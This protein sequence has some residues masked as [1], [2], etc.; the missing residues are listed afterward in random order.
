VVAGS[1]RS[2]GTVV[3]EPTGAAG[4]VVAGSA[5]TAWTVA[6]GAG[7]AWAGSAWT[8]ATWTGATRTTGAAW[9]AGSV[10]STRLLGCGSPVANRGRRAVG[11]AGTRRGAGSTGT[12]T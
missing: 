6:A 10:A 3:T 12:H 5:W 2:A 1:A 4:T 9:A 11:A 8:G 7:A